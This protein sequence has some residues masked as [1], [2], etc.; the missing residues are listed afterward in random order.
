[1]GPGLMGFPTPAPAMPT[2]AVAASSGHAA[3][4]ASGSSALP[5]SQPRLVVLPPPPV[6]AAAIAP[7]LA[8]G[9]AAAAA[10]AATS[11]GSTSAPAAELAAALHGSSSGVA[12]PVATPVHA[13]PPPTPTP[14]YHMPIENLQKRMSMAAGPAEGGPFVG[15][16]PKPTPGRWSRPAAATTPGDA[17]ASHAAPLFQGA[18]SAVLVPPSPDVPMADATAPGSQRADSV[19]R[20]ELGAADTVPRSEFGAADT[21]PRSE[22]RKLA[23]GGADPPPSAA[24]APPSAAPSLPT[25]L[26]VMD[27]DPTS[28][29]V[30][31]SSRH[32]QKEGEHSGSRRKSRKSFTRA[33]AH[34]RSPCSRASRAGA[35]MDARMIISEV[36]RLLRSLQR[37][38]PRW[39]ALVV[40]LRPSASASRSCS[41]ASAPLPLCPSAPPPLRP[42]AFLVS[43]LVPSL[44][45]FATLPLA[46]RDTHECDAPHGSVRRDGDAALDAAA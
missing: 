16:T 15:L 37:R 8:S 32:E 40:S 27:V 1:M 20:S 13:M 22:Y 14:E 29:S 45:L 6:L 23:E 31:G 30:I 39:L 3:P 34:P 42:S 12:A 17:S 33:V 18:P 25:G 26:R 43:A 2:P 28:V 5:F 41:S 38:A 10:A 19:P 36:C 24:H 35:A 44:P 9:A 46:G 11:A 21:V 7:Q 4:L